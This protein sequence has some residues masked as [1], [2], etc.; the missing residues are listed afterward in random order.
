MPPLNCSTCTAYGRRRKNHIH[1][2]VHEGCT[3]LSE[4]SKVEA[5]FHFF[6]GI[7]GT[8]ATQLNTI[9]LDQLNL[10]QLELTGFDTRF[11]KEE[12]WKVIRALPPDKAFGPDG[13]TA[14]FL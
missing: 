6:D 2:L 3:L 8:L 13:F 7:M 14:H 4:E 9:N 10:P 11:T 12:V 5:T 1:N